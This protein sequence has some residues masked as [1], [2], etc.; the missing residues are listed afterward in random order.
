MGRQQS[1]GHDLFLSFT[2]PQFDALELLELASRLKLQSH[3]DTGFAV[4]ARP[5]GANLFRYVLLHVGNQHF[6]EA[7]S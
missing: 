7:I 6:G 1:G 2:D 4:F 5:D 3:L